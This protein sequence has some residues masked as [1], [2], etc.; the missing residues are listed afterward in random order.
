MNIME[1]A[2]LIIKCFD[3][4]SIV[5]ASMLL[6]TFAGMVYAAFRSKGKVRTY[7]HVALILSIIDFLSVT[8]RIMDILTVES[9]NRHIEIAGILLPAATIMF[10]GLTIYLISVILRIIQNPR[11]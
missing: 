6:L 11:I 3:I 9:D 5:I 8:L 2:N 1:Y 4:R 10:I 7:G